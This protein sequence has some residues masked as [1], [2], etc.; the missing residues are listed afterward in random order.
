MERNFF[1]EG[2]ELHLSVDIRISL[3]GGK[4][5]LCWSL[6]SGHSKLSS[7]KFIIPLDL[8]IIHRCA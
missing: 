2:R 7:I 5:L 8:G 3:E 4:E 1:D 6:K